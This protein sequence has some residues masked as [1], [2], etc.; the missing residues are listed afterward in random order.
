MTTSKGRIN[1]YEALFLFPQGAGSD[2]HNVLM[3]LN[4]IFERSSA[5]L[6]AL[7]KWDERKLAYEINKN[8]RGIYFLAYIKSDP[9]NM[10]GFERDCNLSEDIIRF[11]VTRADH[12]TLEEMQAHD[13]RQR[14]QDEAR[15]RAEDLPAVAAPNAA[16][17]DTPTSPLTTP[18]TT[19]ATPE[20]A[21]TPESAEET[22]PADA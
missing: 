16:A 10:A 17:Q 11:M 2:I 9:A 14:L 19:P 12:L 21:Q 18:E 20:T 6:V 7:T 4:T 3:T 8:K 22:T 15:L 1:T 13:N 5:E